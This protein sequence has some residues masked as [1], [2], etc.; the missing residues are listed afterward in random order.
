MLV[1]ILPRI[2]SGTIEPRP[3]ENTRATYD[4]LIHKEAGHIKWTRPALQIER[5][6][7][8]YAGW[9][10]SRTTLGGTELV[11][12]KTHV[13]E[14]SGPPGKPFIV[15]KTLAVYC[16]DGALAIDRLKP[17]GRQEMDTAAFLAGYGHNIIP[18][19]NQN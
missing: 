19:P 4:S 14:D 5:E 15:G 11:I 3:Q 17:A 6:I 18:K 9:P 2:I 12:T 7:R 13:V 8:A 10:K 1:E 16:S